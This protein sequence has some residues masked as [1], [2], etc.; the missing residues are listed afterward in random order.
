MFV[1][2]RSNYGGVKNYL[3]IL[4]FFRVTIIQVVFPS[5]LELSRIPCKHTDVMWPHAWKW[6]C[7]LAL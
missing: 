1:S 2:L 3:L 6:E 5:V 4:E 7:H